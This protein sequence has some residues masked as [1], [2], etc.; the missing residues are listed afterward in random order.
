M[1]WPASCR[2]K[3]TSDIQRLSQKGKEVAGKRPNVL[4]SDGAPNFHDAYQKEFWTL[5]NPRTKRVQYI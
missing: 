4:I 1:D 3:N 5:K 2:Q